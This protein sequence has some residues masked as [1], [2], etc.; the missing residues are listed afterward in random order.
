MGAAAAALAVVAIV[1]V[2][3]LVTNRND[4]ATTTEPATTPSVEPSA[5]APATPS[6]SAADNP[7]PAPPGSVAKPKSWPSAP[8]KADAAGK[9]FTVTLKTSCGDIGLTLDGTKAPQAVASSVF[10]AKNG[11]YDNTPCHRLTTAGIFVLQCG[12]PTGTGSG[13]PGYSY[14]PVE[15]APSNNV[16]PAGT[17]AMA[18]QSGDG[19]S[20][21][22]QFFLVYQESSIPSDGAGGY[23]VLGKITSGLDALKKVTEGGVKNGGGDGEP[24]RAVSIVSSVVKAG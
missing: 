14:G 7:C 16:Y 8:P 3:L 2:T 1:V 24:A 4:G 23:T 11:F 15:N 22:S 17:V 18:R 20:M 6:A 13:G 10:L 12:D 5:S 9:T 19:S 21:G